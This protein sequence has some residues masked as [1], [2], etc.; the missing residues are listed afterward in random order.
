MDIIGIWQI[1]WFCI[2]LIFGQTVLHH[3]H[4]MMLY[5]I[6]IYIYIY[7]SAA[8]A[9]ASFGNVFFWFIVLDIVLATVLTRQQCFI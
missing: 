5:G 1:H 4:A 7:R 8:M 6:Y 9:Q 3:T 2:F